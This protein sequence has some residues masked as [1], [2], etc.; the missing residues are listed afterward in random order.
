MCLFSLENHKKLFYFDMKFL[1]EFKINNVST[2]D[3]SVFLES[4]KLS[5]PNAS[6]A[7]LESGVS[8]TCRKCSNVISLKMVS[9]LDKPKTLYY[10]CC[11]HNVAFLFI[12]TTFSVDTPDVFIFAL[13]ELYC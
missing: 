5:I 9:A 1:S 7:S 10:L 8:V 11:S 2:P 13:Q 3:V 4:I 6:R 12:N